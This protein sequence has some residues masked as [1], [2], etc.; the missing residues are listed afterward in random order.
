MWSAERKHSGR[1]DPSVVACIVWK[2]AQGLGGGH[3]AASGFRV[4]WRWIHN[5]KP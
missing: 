3:K 1:K 5:P 4:Q 2:G